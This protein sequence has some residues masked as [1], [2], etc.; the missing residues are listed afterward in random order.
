MRRTLPSLKPGGGAKKKRG[1]EALVLVG[2][3]VRG[4]QDWEEWSYSPQ[5]KRAQ[6]QRSLF[7]I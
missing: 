2:V 5:P 4:S 6:S 7:S 1:G 3:K